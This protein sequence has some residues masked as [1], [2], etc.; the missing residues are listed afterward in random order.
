MMRPWTY[1][2]M[3]VNMSRRAIMVKYQV[4]ILATA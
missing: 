2:M 1:S 3:P 4:S